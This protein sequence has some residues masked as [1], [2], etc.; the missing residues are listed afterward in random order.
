[1]SL[2]FERPPSGFHFAVIFELLPQAPSDFRFQ[3]V[4][5]LTSTVETEDFKEGGENRFTHKLPKR[6][7]YSSLELKRGMFTGSFIVDWCREAIEN[8]NFKPVNITVMLLND[9]HLPIAGWY[10][11]N[12]YPIEWSTSGFNAQSSDL[13]VESIKLNY[14]YFNTL[15][16]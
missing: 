5:G 8:F 1:M 12:A 10:V 13:V 6:S 3:E 7:S 14:S 15:R 16:I 11:V 2:L 9:L 4:S